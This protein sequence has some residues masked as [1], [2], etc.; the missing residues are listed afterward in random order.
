MRPLLFFLLLLAV[1]ASCGNRVT[2]YWGDLPPSEPLRVLPE[3]DNYVS[4]TIHEI[5]ENQRYATVRIHNRSLHT[6]IAGSYFR[7]EYFNATDWKQ[8]PSR[9]G[10]LLGFFSNIVAQVHPGEYGDVTKDLWRFAS[11]RPGLYRIRKYV[12][13]RIDGFSYSHDVVAEFTWM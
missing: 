13:I 3:I 10:D 4:M 6:A 2:S 1:L 5:C 11:L 12:L 8:I 9:G 7:V